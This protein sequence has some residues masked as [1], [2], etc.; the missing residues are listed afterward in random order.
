MLNRIVE[1]T[2]GQRTRHLDPQPSAQH[3]EDRRAHLGAA[4]RP[5]TR[6]APL[7]IRRPTLLLLWSLFFFAACSSDEP[8]TPL[9]TASAVAN[10]EVTATPNTPPLDIL[11]TIT[12]TPT[13]PPATPSPAAAPSGLWAF[14]VA[15]GKQVVLYQGAATVASQIDASDNAATTT[16]TDEG[17]TTAVRFRP[18]GTRIEEHADRSLIVT[19]ANGDS[20]FYLNIS[21]PASPQLVLEH[22]G[23]VVRLEGTRPRIGISFSPSGE[24]LLVVSER[25]GAA[26]GE[27]VRTFSVHSTEDGRLRMQFEHQAMLGAPAIANWSPSGRYVADRGLGGLFV[28]DTVTGRAW[29]LGPEGSN[30]WSPLSDQLL[31]ITDLGRLVIVSI[32]ELSGIDLGPI[33]QSASVSFD[34]SGQLVIATTYGDPEER[35]SRST[36][37]FDVGSGIEIAAWPGMDAARYAVEGL[38]AVIALHDGIAAIFATATGCD[39]GFIAI[40]PALGDDQRCILG[41]NPRWSPNAQ[42]L[43]YNRDR[44]VVLLSLSSDVER[45][46]ARGTP[47]ADLAGGPSLRWSRDGTWILIQWPADLPTDQ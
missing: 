13:A 39:G 45:V 38:D 34:R 16:I 19:A 8:P 5:P 4:P 21:D 28:R 18:D 17:G 11:P 29:R 1:S 31:A 12:A 33:D 42:L 35:G 46:I 30:R 3:R 37:A 9:A 7:V 47:P 15:R 10:L 27:V 26:E 25:P 22:H 43:V 2:I 32:P 36:R 20:R 24:R 14:D 23:E 40:H 41:A 44:E 6:W